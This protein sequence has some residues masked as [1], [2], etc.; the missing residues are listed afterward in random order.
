MFEIIQ[1]SWQRVKNAKNFTFFR[2][3]RYCP[4][5]ARDLKKKIRMLKILLVT[6][7]RK[8]VK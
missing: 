3:P 7:S 8:H 4:S 2:F 6:L 1:A 5:T